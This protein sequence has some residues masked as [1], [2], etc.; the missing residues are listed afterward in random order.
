MKVILNN[1]QSTEFTNFRQC[2]TSRD[3]NKLHNYL[4]KFRHSKCLQNKDW[5]IKMSLNLFCKFSTAC[6][7][8]Q[9]VIHTV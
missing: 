8:I 6:T 2:I 7:S 1:S 3:I 4:Y 5:I 9:K